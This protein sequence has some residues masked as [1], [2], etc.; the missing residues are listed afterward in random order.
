[1]TRIPAAETANTVLV[2][3]MEATRAEERRLDI[4]PLKFGP[5]V[6]KNF[7]QLRWHRHLDKLRLLYGVDSNFHW[8]V[9]GQWTVHQVVDCPVDSPVDG[10]VVHE[11]FRGIRLAI[12][13]STSYSV[14]LGSHEKSSTSE[15]AH[16]PP[17]F[18][19]P[20]RP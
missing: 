13:H 7:A 20:Q 10:V 14:T 18:K 17:I 5:V 2:L 8:R 16:W 11:H 1:M 6:Q 9:G 12:L 4:G 19:V 3:A 15:L